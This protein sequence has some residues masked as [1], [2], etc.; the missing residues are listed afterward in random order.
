MF[1]QLNSL[2][3]LYLSG[4]KFTARQTAQ[5]MAGLNSNKKLRNS[6]KWLSF[7]SN[8]FDDA[9]TIE[10]AKFVAGSSSIETIMGAPSE[11][12][13]VLKQ[14]MGR[15][16]LEVARGCDNQVIANINTTKTKLPKIY[17]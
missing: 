7:M 1:N 3:Q 6:L 16:F 9:A 15:Y 14:S 4:N 11:Y 5:L 8:N 13:F 17:D 10:F 2:K 12:R